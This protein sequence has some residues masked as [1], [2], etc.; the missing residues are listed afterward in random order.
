LTI[1]LSAN[2]RDGVFFDGVQE[3]VVP[4]GSL[5]TSAEKL[6]TQTR[7]SRQTIRS[8][9]FSESNPRRHHQNNQALDHAN[10]KQS[11]DSSAAMSTEQPKDEPSVRPP[12]GLQLPSEPTNGVTRSGTTIEE[13][14]INSK[15]YM[16]NSGELDKLSEL[17]LEPKPKTRRDRAGIDPAIQLWF[18]AEFWP[19]YPRHEAKGRALQAA[20]KKA[21]IPE[22]RAFYVERLKTQLSEYRRRKSESGQ[23]VIPLAATWFNQDRAD[24]ELPIQ[25]PSPSRGG[26]PAVVENDYPEYVPLKAS[27]AGI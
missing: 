24:D 11:E 2:W 23:R 22:K 15:E 4:A 6:A 7:T 5:V 19:I 3:I 17:R 13:R 8:L 25:E 16:S 26:R 18:E 10:H 1:L 14:R 12:I 21:T 20:G 27:K 9:F